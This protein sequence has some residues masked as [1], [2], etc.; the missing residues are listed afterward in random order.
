MKNIF[1][2][3]GVV[4]TVNKTKLIFQLRDKK[5]SIF[6]PGMIGLFGGSIENNESPIN[7]I[8]RE[9]L[10]EINI[11]ISPARFKNIAKTNFSCHNLSNGDERKR[12]FFHLNI[13][14][15]EEKDINLSEGDALKKFSYKDLPSIQK[16]VP[17]DLLAIGIYISELNKIK[18]NPT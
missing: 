6:Y 13:S 8:K 14:E 7:C 16:I 10:E 17:T 18:I 3:C 2:S 4:L 9:I 15:K 5:N 11:D 12:F 1:S